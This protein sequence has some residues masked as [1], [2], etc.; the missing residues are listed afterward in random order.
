MTGR[1]GFARWGFASAILMAAFAAASAAACIYPPPSP[2]REGESDAEW[3][4]R[5]KAEFESKQRENQKAREA[6]SFDQAERVYLA[7]VIKSEEIANGDFRYG[8]SVRVAPLAAIKG[9]LPS[10]P[11]TLG[12]ATMTS[13]GPE[14]EGSAV[15]APVAALAIIFEGVE[16][17]GFKNL[18]NWSL[19]PKEVQDERIAAPAREYLDKNRRYGSWPAE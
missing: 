14:S 12:T 2:Q 3:Q 17:Y 4:V 1:G 16:P 18:T 7:R 5:T 6:E 10:E 13:C 8:R 11:T 15:W 9:A 19:L